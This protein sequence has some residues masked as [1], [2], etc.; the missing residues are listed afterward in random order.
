MTQA[1]QIDIHQSVL[2]DLKSRLAK[3]RWTDE[4][5]NSNWAYGTNKTYLRELCNYWQRDFDWREQEQYLNSFHHFKAT[6]DGEGVHYIHQKGKGD[7]AIPLLLIHGYPDS[8]IRFLKIIPLLTKADA[9]GFSFDV[10]IPSIPGYGFSGI[11]RKPGMNAQRIADLFAELVTNELGYK[12]FIAHGGDQ[13]SSITEQ[14]A[15]KHPGSLAGIHLTEIPFYHLFTLPPEELTA[16]EK[17]YLDTGKQWQQTEG[18]YGMIQSTKPQ[19]LAYGLNDS[20]AGLA[21]WIIEKFHSWSDCR[22]DLERC[23]TKNE[24]LTNLTIYWATQTINSAFRLYY[25]SMQSM[26]GPPDKKT[27]RIEVPTAVAMFPKDLVNAPKDF[28]NRFFNIRQWTDMPKGGHF[29][30]MEQPALLAADIRKFV[31]GLNSTK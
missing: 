29:T 13:G 10:I 12:K 7:H 15:L 11:P 16:A 1:F 26:P 2:D 19:T 24:L 21:A 31:M 22:G 3:T 28:A 20:P 6:I 14:L 17:K 18:A 23:F 30:A 5:E 8:F 4:I 9:S 25:E 27:E